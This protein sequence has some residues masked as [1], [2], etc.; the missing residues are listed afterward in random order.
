MQCGMLRFA[1][2]SGQR[3]AKARSGVLLGDVLGPYRNKP[4]NE[5]VQ[6]IQGS[7][8]TMVRGETSAYTLARLRRRGLRHAFIP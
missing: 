6:F 1:P 3:T 7:N 8:R 2:L 5:K 4:R